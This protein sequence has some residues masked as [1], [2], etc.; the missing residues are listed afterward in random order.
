MWGPRQPC[1]LFWTERRAFI[2]QRMYLLWWTRYNCPFSARHGCIRFGS[3]KELLM[4]WWQKQEVIIRGQRWTVWLKQ[5]QNNATIAVRC[6]TILQ[7]RS[8]C[9][10]MCLKSRS[11]ALTNTS[12]AV[13]ER[14]ATGR[15]LRAFKMAGSVC[16]YTQLIRTTAILLALCTRY[17]LCTAIVFDKGSQFTAEKQNFCKS[18]GIMHLL[19][20]QPTHNQMVKLNVTSYRENYRVCRTA[21]VS[22]KD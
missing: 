17:D 14:E 19:H 11:S 21:S 5:P 15:S 10:G 6:R 16:H 8:F 18:D 4:G 12:Q 22:K 20:N 9:S 3:Q 13:S 1:L 7:N 2:C